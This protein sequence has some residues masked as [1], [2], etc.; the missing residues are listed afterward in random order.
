MLFY[1]HKPVDSARLGQNIHGESL[2][3]RNLTAE[4]P[5]AGR[6]E[7]ARQWHPDTHNLK[8]WPGR[9]LQ[10]SIRQW[11]SFT[12]HPAEDAN[13]LSEHMV[14]E[15]SLEKGSRFYA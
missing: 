13:L 11:P 4:H 7:A 1:C 3:R 8:P 14:K 5:H 15:I 10:I 9:K 12:E 2:S 6:R